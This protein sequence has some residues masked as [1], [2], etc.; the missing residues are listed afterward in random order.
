MKRN[1]SRF[2]SNHHRG[3]FWRNRIISSGAMNSRPPAAITMVVV[4]LPVSVVDCQVPPETV[5]SRIRI[6]IAQI[7]RKNVDRRSRSRSG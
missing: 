6:G 7:S 3:Y 5:P 2:Q 4:V 1:S